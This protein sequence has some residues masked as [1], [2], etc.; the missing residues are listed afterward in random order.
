MKKY[1]IKC[2]R[3]IKNKKVKPSAFN[4]DTSSDTKVVE[5]INIVE[6]E[7]SHCH[8]LN[9][10]DSLAMMDSH[11]FNQHAHN[12][13]IKANDKKDNGLCFLVIGIIL[14]IVGAILF[15]LSFKKTTYGRVFRPASFE[16]ALGVFLLAISTLAIIYSIIKLIKAY[17]AKKFFKSILRDVDYK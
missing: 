6:D 8:T 11:E 13:I 15:V 16:F 14:V 5:N 17:K 4:A 2:G 12:N 10:F 7:C 1:C 9:D 3:L